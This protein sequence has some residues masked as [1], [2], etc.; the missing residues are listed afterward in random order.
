MTRQWASPPAPR[1][2]ILMFSET[3]D[4]C[5]A[6]DDPIRVLDRVLNEMD[7]GPWEEAYD[8]GRG[9][10]AIHPRL[11]AGCIL[12][13]LMKGLRST[14]ALE[15]ATRHRVDFMWFL[16]RRTIDHTTFSYFR[17]DFKAELK[18]LSRQISR[19]ICADAAK[20]LLEIVLDGTRLRANSDRHGARTAQ[21]LERLM[22]AVEEELNEK[23]EKLRDG[24]GELD[25]NQAD[26]Q[27]LQKEVD[28]LERRMEKYKRALAVARERDETKRKK[29]GKKCLGVRVPVTDPDA[30]IVPNKEGG[31]APNYTPVV[32]VDRATGAIVM[33]DVV[34]GSDEA[35]AVALA[36]EA[37]EELFERKPDRVLA[38]TSFASG[39]NL[40]ALE[41]NGIEASMPAG[42][43]FRDSNPANRADPTQA[44]APEDRERLPRHKR[45]LARSAFVFDEEKDRYYCPMGKALEKTSKSGAR[46]ARYACPGKEDCPLA[47]ECV[48]REAERR[49]VLRD[50]YQHLRDRVGKRMAGAEGQR[51]YK[52]RAPVVEGVFG[53]I[54]AAMRIRNF[55]LRGL[56]NVRTEW[57]WICAAFNLRK[58][59]QRKGG[60]APRVAA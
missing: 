33:S 42:T 57:N 44:V 31:F 46:E 7:W 28:G 39:E 2:Q 15:D 23:L 17:T 1:H 25:L 21:G 20:A 48:K 9:Q 41:E 52:K 43:D 56:G 3:L 50:K 37:A 53:V 54:K 60:L 11:I 10:P 27:T 47:A 29:E 34:E 45:L 36:V 49:T 16:E 58:L 6:P 14:R 18:D 13:G 32:A 24:D 35:S 55:L 59:L 8:G 51:V 4:D 38:D 22:A 5:V 40:E 12:Y 26:T 19:A 30:M